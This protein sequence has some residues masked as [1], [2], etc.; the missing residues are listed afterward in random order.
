MNRWGFVA[1]VYWLLEQVRTKEVLRKRV[2]QRLLYRK[3]PY[4]SLKHEI[5]AMK[6]APAPIK[7]KWKFYKPRRVKN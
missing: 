6:S 1:P 3:P 4:C 5:H 7:R 2:R